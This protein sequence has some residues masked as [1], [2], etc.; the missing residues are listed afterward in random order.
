IVA[1][2]YHRVSG[3]WTG[4]E[5]GPGG[6]ALSVP[7]GVLCRRSLAEHLDAD[8]VLEVTR[9]GLG[10]YH[11]GFG[12]PYP[13]GKY[14]QVFVPEYNLGAMENPGCVTFTEKYVFR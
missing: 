14:D 10:F 4:P 2:P 9:Q 8:A 11:D 13:W 1:V 5:A 3:E 7:L 6:E 12:Y